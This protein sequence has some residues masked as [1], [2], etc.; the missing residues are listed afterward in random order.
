V[1]GA[2]GTAS[3]TNGAHSALDHRLGSVAAA[4]DVL[5]AHNHAVTGTIRARFH[6]HVET[7]PQTWRDRWATGS[8]AFGHTS[9]LTLAV[10]VTL[11]VDGGP[12]AASLPGAARFSGSASIASP[13]HGADERV[14]S[15]P[16][17]SVLRG[18]IHQ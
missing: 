1:R 2:G 5:A 9:G 8:A 13:T 17:V 11:L 16:P 18:A 15:V 4:H 14:A 7:V 12:C 10:V 3:S 6:D